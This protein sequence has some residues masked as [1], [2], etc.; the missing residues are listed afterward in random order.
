[1]TPTTRPTFRRGDAV[2]LI[3]QVPG[4]SRLRPGLQGRVVVGDEVA[5]EWGMV[6][7][8]FA[9]LG[10]RPWQLHRRHLRRLPHVQWE[11]PCP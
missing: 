4:R 2:E 5:S 11:T 6:T 8:C 9:A 1:M 10:N 7:V 3:D